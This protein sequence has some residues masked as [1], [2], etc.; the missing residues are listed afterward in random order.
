[1]SLPRG[2]GPVLLALSAAAITGC[3]SRRGDERSERELALAAADALYERRED[4]AKLVEAQ[5][6]ALSM[7]ARSPEDPEVLWR[8]ARAYTAYAYGYPEAPG[9]PCG[10]PGEPAPE[11]C[12]AL[13]M[14]YA[15]RC[16]ETKPAWASR[17]MINDGRITR[18]IAQTLGPEEEDCLEQG[19][20]AWT[21]WVALRGPSAGIYL[22]SIRWLSARAL[23]LDEQSWVG[24]W[25]RAMVEALK[26]PI[27]E[28]DRAVA[29][30]HF[31]RAAALA[32]ELA[33][34]PT[35]RAIYVLAETDPEAFRAAIDAIERTYGADG[36][37]YALENR[38]SLERLRAR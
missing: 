34:P 17:L 4:R 16:M 9:D 24:H 2:G 33:V 5:E 19:I 31:E 26:P 1:M 28:P 30:E 3:H 36:T 35:D 10:V 23:E 20:V 27:A 29:E 12:Y 21:R 11:R 38:R 14:E 13:A 25:G 18:R 22:E 37:A 15:F 6:A 8:L 7:L 32:P